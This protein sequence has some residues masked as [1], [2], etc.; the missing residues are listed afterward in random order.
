MSGEHFTDHLP[1]W[2]HWPTQMETLLQNNNFADHLIVLTR[3]DTGAFS[4]EIQ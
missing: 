3:D 2:L 4:M 1:K